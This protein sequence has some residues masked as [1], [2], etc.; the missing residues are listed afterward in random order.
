MAEYIKSIVFT[1]HVKE[2]MNR[3]GIIREEIVNALLNPDS[4]VLWL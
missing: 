4:I 3:Y 2:C 1:S